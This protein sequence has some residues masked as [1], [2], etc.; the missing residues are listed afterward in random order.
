L[1]YQQ[2]VLPEGPAPLPMTESEEHTETI[3]ARVQRDTSS[4]P[5]RP[6]VTRTEPNAF[7]LLREYYGK[8]PA[9]D[10]D[11]LVQLEGLLVG[12]A[13]STSNN[14]RCASAHSTSVAT[15]RVDPFEVLNA[16][17]DALDPSVYAPW[18]TMSSALLAQWHTGG[19]SNLKSLASLTSL[20]DDVLLHPKFKLDEIRGVAW[21]SYLRD[22]GSDGED[23]T[24]HAPDGWKKVDVPILVPSWDRKLASYMY[25][26]PGLLFRPISQV[27]RTVCESERAKRFHFTPYRL[28]WKPGQGAGEQIIQGE[29]YT[30]T[31]FIDEHHKIQQLAKEPGC[32]LPRAMIALLIASDSTHLAQFGTAS[33]WPAYL[34]FGNESKY[35]RG[36]P[37]ACACHHIAYIPKVGFFSSIEALRLPLNPMSSAP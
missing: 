21:S 10:P 13:E 33:L 23:S 17:L 31:A 22:M 9:H 34:M 24:F 2:D 29:F 26:V 18:P 36:R 3:E 5:L 32:D 20:V 37:S 35:D 12:E 1:R 19:P 15:N 14:E 8:L 4:L 27:I 7:G 6:Q 11:E 28:I 25:N 30:T 16:E